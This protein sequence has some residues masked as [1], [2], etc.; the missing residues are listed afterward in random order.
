MIDISVGSVYTADHV[1][2]G[3]SD[4]GAWELIVLRENS[5]GKTKK[6]ITL[7][8]SKTPSGVTSGS[9]FVIDDITRI[10][11]GA[12]KGKDGQWR[13]DVSVY[14]V[15][16]PDTDVSSSTFEDLNDDNTDLPF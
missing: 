10:K 11:Y 3:T 7:W 4:R 5:K 12:K 15:L 13:D 2:S 14:C 1:A 16:H 6:S 8:P 9:Q